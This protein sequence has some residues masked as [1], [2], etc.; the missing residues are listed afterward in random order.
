M[1][2]LNF[3]GVALPSRVRGKADD[4]IECRTQRKG[5]ERES[6][7][8]PLPTPSGGH[9]H[10]H[11]LSRRHFDLRCP[12]P[13]PPHTHTPL[14]LGMLRGLLTVSISLL[15]SPEPSVELNATPVLVRVESFIYVCTETNTQMN[16]KMRC[17]ELPS[18]HSVLQANLPSSKIICRNSGKEGAW[19]TQ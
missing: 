18:F 1:T 5:Q 6:G 17:C 9:L 7:A 2:Q 12:T 8:V 16:T 10:P 13:P 4:F 15:Q 14:A 19:V 11:H 3:L